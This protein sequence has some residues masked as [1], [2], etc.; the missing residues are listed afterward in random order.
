MLL[1]GIDNQQPP[2]TSLPSGAR[3]PD[4]CDT[5]LERQRAQVNDTMLINSLLRNSIQ[6]QGQ[7]PIAVQSQAMPTGMSSSP[8]RFSSVASLPVQQQHDQRLV[9]LL[10]PPPSVMLG[11]HNIPIQLQGSDQQAVSAEQQRLQPNI[12]TFA[13]DTVT[14]FTL[15][16]MN[17]RTTGC[18]AHQIQTP[19]P[20]R[21]V[22]EYENKLQVVAL[23]DID[24]KAGFSLPAAKGPG[25]TPTVG[26][27]TKYRRIWSQLTEKANS[28]TTISAETFVPEFFLRRI[29]QEINGG[30]LYRKIHQF[31]GRVSRPGKRTRLA[32]E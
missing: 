22:A 19:G 15:S 17:E 30:H 5:L 6:R 31:P 9:S 2:G 28:S 23:S 14:S 1:H 20:N 4:L 21:C 27:L 7:Q 25:K 32:K 11:D 16:N 12:Q 26:P 24:K 8:G 29:S 10:P 13:E 3:G 18:F